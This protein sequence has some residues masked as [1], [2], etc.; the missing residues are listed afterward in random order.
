[1]PFCPTCGAETTAGETRC[2]DCGSLLAAAPDRQ[3]S[4]DRGLDLVAGFLAGFLALVVGFVTTA[5][6]SDIQE[7]RE[8]AQDILASN[9][10]VGVALSELLPEWYHIVGWVF[11]E[12]HQVGISV[13]VG[14]MFG[15]G[16]WVGE[17][18]ETLLPTAPEL[19]FLPPL[20][21]VGAGV[22]VTL[23]RPRMGPADAVIAGVTVVAGYL[24]GIA[25]VTY[26]ATFEAVV[27]GDVV[28]IE[29]G[30]DFGWAI[31]LAGVTYPLM[32][33]GLGGLL[34]FVLGRLLLG[35]GH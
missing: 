6:L 19:Q 33:G 28:L 2:A 29:I 1:M 22:L 17:Y 35:W 11:L 23:R 10:P 9:G 30:P 4:A 16:A 31:L 5:A 34:V 14:E 13:R 25:L 7:N 20:L 12:S 3:R 18:A 26:I 32:F 15:S 8:L 24:P 21:L 27:F